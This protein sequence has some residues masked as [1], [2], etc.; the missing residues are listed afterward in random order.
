MLKS[1]STAF[2]AKARLEITVLS[3]KDDTSKV[4]SKFVGIFFIFLEISCDSS[5]HS[6][7]PEIAV[8]MTHIQTAWVLRCEYEC[9][10]NSWVFSR[11]SFAWEQ[12]TFLHDED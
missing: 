5:H 3:Q 12:R 7:N 8:K 6:V 2:K 1:I 4:K 9:A 10:L 11:F